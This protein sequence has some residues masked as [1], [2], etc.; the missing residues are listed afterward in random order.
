MIH[1]LRRAASLPFLL[2]MTVLLAGCAGS[3]TSPGTPPPPP[4][5]V[6]DSTMIPG[7][8]GLS[9][10][11]TKALPVVILSDSLYTLEVTSAA[12][13]MTSGHHFT[14]AITTR[15]TVDGNVSI[16]TDTVAGTWSVSGLTIT[17]VSA[18]D[19]SVA[20]ATWDATHLVVTQMD[21]TARDSYGYV[22]KP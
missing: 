15:E 3:P 12:A 8:Y 2:A 22:R 7:S 19:G 14:I 10:V 21:A 16:Y 4:P 6:V 18:A 11:N 9:T 5:A 13:T 20:T 17:L 1:P